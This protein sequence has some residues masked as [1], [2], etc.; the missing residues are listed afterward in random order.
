M[1]RYVVVIW[2]SENPEQ[3]NAAERIASRLKTANWHEPMRASG[4]RVLQ[5]GV[6]PGGLETQV[7]NNSAGA[8]IGRTF[9]R[10]PDV[11]DETPAPRWS[12]NTAETEAILATC[13]RWLIERC[14]GNYIAVLRSPDHPNRVA[15]LKDPTGTLPCF[16]TQLTGM[17]LIFSLADDL[18]RLG[19]CRFTINRAY[20]RARVLHG[21]DASQRPLNEVDQVHRGERV[22]IDTEATRLHSR[23]Y[24]WRPKTFI[25]SDDAFEDR[26]LAARA[27]R[28]IVRMSTHTLAAVDT[29]IVHRLSGGLDSSIIAGC[30]KDA[31]SRPDV[32]CYTYFTPGAPADERP[33]ARLVAAHVNF[34]HREVPVTWQHIDLRRAVQMPLL[35]EPASILMYTLRSAIEQGIAISAKA[36]IVFNGDGGDS[37]LGADAVRYAAFEYLRRRGLGLSLLSIAAQV[38]SRTQQTAWGVLSNAI[39]ACLLGRCAD[40]M[41]TMRPELSRLCSRD[42]LSYVPISVFPWFADE[43]SIPWALVRRLG[44]LVGS[45]QFYDSN[46][47]EGAPEVI[48]PLYAQPVIETLLRVPLYRL[49]EDGRDR[50]LARRAFTLEVPEPILRRLWKDRAPGLH[51][52]VIFHN[53]TFLRE[54]FLEGALVRE[55]LI[56]GAAIEE[57]FGDLA[58]RN[59]A[60][61]VEIFRQLELEMW[62]RAWESSGRASP[63]SRFP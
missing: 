45:P 14:W 1:F 21:A 32:C 49:F 61:P 10:S 34:E 23:Q 38:A 55:G 62:V 36:S 44:A 50:G 41:E 9:A 17:T 28:A 6:R 35:V 20:L 25:D 27:M 46:T 12:A 39:G 58:S 18:V 48:S 26:H 8:I 57:T 11:L 5:T 42:L 51:E 47:N 52:Q 7:L 19:L 4:L 31:P 24:L 13:G 40:P 43:P 53:R 63:A 33:W 60:L 22:E 54:A 59:Q 3:A 16:V 15:V 29:N 37:I 30:L 56:S 2:C